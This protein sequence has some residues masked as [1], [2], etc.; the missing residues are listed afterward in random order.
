MKEIIKFSVFAGMSI[1]GMCIS[2]YIP[3]QWFW[4][5]VIFSLFLG[6]IANHYIYKKRSTSNEEQIPSTASTDDPIFNEADFNIR[7]YPHS[8]IYM[9]MYQ[10]QYMKTESFT[11]IIRLQKDVL[12]GIGCPDMLTA[13]TYIERF[14]SQNF[15]IGLVDIPYNVKEYHFDKKL[16]EAEKQIE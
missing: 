8:G 16:A 12:F 2:H 1:L 15:E 3:K 7:H 5:W 4:Y 6:H 9:P 14:I 10:N 11:H 13:H